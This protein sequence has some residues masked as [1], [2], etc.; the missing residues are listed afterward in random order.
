MVVEGVVELPLDPNYRSPQLTEADGVIVL[1]GGSDY[2][3]GIRP[4][5]IRAT[6]SAGGRFSVTA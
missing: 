2:R 6:S 5:L 3:G 1:H 4:A